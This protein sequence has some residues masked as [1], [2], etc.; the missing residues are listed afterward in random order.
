MAEE[1][2][3]TYSF[4]DVSEPVYFK[5]SD[6]LKEKWLNVQIK[7]DG[8]EKEL[9]FTLLEPN[10]WRCKRCGFNVNSKE[11]PK[12]C[13]ECNKK[14]DF[15]QLTDSFDN[16]K[17]L[18]CV[19][20]W[21]D[22]EV[23]MFEVYDDIMKILKK[24]IKFVEEIHYKLFALWII[25]T[26]KHPTWETIPYF[27]FKGLP[28]SGKTRAMEVAKLLAYRAVLVSAITF[29]AVVRINHH[30]NATLLID[31]IDT[32]VDQR[33]E[34]GRMYTD[35]LKSG[36]KKGSL[37][38]SSDLNDQ[39]KVL[40]YKNYG[41][42]ILTGEKGINNEALLSR[43]LVFDMHQDVPDVFD[44]CEVEKDCEKIRTKLI[45]YRYKT[46]NPKHLQYEVPLKARYREIFDCLIRTAEHI[47]Q[48]SDDLLE[49]AKK[50]EQRIVDEMQGT[51]EYDVLVSIFNRSCQG[52]L[53]AV[54]GIKTSEILE[55]L[56]WLEENKRKN[57]I[58][59]GYILKNLGLR[60]KRRKDGM[61]LFTSE[62]D[63]ER[64][65]RY[66]LRRYRVNS[67]VNSLQEWG[68]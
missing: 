35:F 61:W 37:Y 39:S 23:D 56:G 21:E 38:V 30:F 16:P 53:D 14:V 10:V 31:E 13:P 44:L 4:N 24:T 67:G 19:P 66:L 54:E 34:L 8:E 7:S 43:T 17:N 32:K 49:Y 11:K 1:D 65:L 47:G 48:K 55:D 60:T 45:N 68:E 63:N 33:T 3:T 41:P 22:I 51:V 64:Q 5:N 52:T 59:L 27:N 46:D 29:T 42:K 40:Y 20:I 18:W 62:A 58:K 15:E 26:Y 57:S 25:A 9:E 50:Q 28:A 12:F 2:L 6:L 36:Y